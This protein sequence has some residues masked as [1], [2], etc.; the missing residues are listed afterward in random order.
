[1]KRR[2]PFTLRLCVVLVLLASLAS[3]ALDSR[4]TSEIA[5]SP[6]FGGSSVS[7]TDVLGG[8]Y[9]HLPLV[10]KELPPYV[11]L[12]SWGNDAGRFSFP[13]AYYKE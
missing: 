2:L 12:R 4:T 8:H 6:L 5:A 11:F 10:P 7:Q 9:A 13:E 1:M 3:S